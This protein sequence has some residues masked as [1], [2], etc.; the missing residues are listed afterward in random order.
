MNELIYRPI[1]E[2]NLYEAVENYG[3][4]LRYRDQ[5]DELI[6]HTRVSAL[7]ENEDIT[8][9]CYIHKPVIPF[10]PVEGNGY[11]FKAI[12]ESSECWSFDILRRVENSNTNSVFYIAKSD[13][14]YTECRPCTIEERDK[15]V[16]VEIGE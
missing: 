10:E 8:H 2:Y 3:I 13:F 5:G 7:I 11:M 9:F 14:Y 12:L 6:N 4:W 1:A 15:Y 16:P